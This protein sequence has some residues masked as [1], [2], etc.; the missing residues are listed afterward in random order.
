[1]KHLR[2]TLTVATLI[3]VFLNLHLAAQDREN[4][5]LPAISQTVLWTLTEAT[6]WI[7]GSDGQWL[8]GKNKIQCLD[9]SSGDAERFEKDINIVGLDN[10][11]KW[12]ARDIT[13]EGKP[14]LILI[15]NYKVA[16]YEYPEFKKGLKIV[17][18]VTFA[19][20]KKNGSKY[21]PKNPKGPVY[22]SSLY[23]WGTVKNSANLFND[24]GISINKMSEKNPWISTSE[25]TSRTLHIYY[26]VLD[27]PTKSRFF[28]DAYITDSAVEHLFLPAD[29]FLIQ[30]DV[31]KEAYF[32][33]ATSAFSGLISLIKPI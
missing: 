12:E 32:E 3:L 16:D 26:K 24:I 6:G 20:I 21:S 17:P 28:T 4:K 5:N 13:V 10:F 25:G 33:V 29:V 19:V 30:R 14:F 22:E 8:S 18:K 23:Y 2:K 31:V 27:D 11:S 15:K 7:K 9:L 1:M